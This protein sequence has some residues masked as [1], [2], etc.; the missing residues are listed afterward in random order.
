MA[1]LLGGRCSGHWIRHQHVAVGDVLLQL[2]LLVKS[3]GITGSRFGKP[4]EPLNMIFSVCPSKG[5]FTG[6]TLR[7]PVF[8][9]NGPVSRRKW[10]LLQVEGANGGFW[11]S[12]INW[13][14]HSS[15]HFA[16][17]GYASWM[18]KLSPFGVSSF[19]TWFLACLLYI[20]Y[21]QQY[22]QNYSLCFFE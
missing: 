3:S 22:A 17:T 16:L 9:K 18:S 8:W 2:D 4:W 7:Y 12:E 5:W 20:G 6:Y 13:I 10:D 14:S 15:G 1:K 19:N 11:A 21:R